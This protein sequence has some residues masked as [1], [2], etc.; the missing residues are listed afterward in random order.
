MTYKITVLWPTNVIPKTI[1]VDRLEV[2]SIIWGIMKHNGND[3][4]LR[5]TEVKKK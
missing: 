3:V 4:D 2:G 5:I 1:Y